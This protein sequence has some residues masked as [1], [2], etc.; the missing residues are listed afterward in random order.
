M[1]KQTGGAYTADEL[2]EMEQKVFLANKL[3]VF[4]VDPS[5]FIHYYVLN[6]ELPNASVRNYLLNFFT[7]MSKNNW[8]KP[9]SEI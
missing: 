4:A 7:S 5:T 6:L 9:D 8:R 1:V 2:I 3:D